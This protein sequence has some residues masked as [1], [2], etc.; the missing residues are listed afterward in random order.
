[1]SA[2]QRGEIHLLPSGDDW[3]SELHI[4]T[5]SGRSFHVGLVRTTVD[6]QLRLNIDDLVIFSPYRGLGLGRAALEAV[7]LDAEFA[8]LHGIVWRLGVEDLQNRK[9]LMRFFAQA[10]FTTLGDSATLALA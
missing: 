3:T 5:P 1:M 10:G 7:R 4:R 6:E 2:E 8:C 9:R